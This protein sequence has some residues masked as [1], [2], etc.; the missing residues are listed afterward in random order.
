MDGD[1]AKHPQ[2]SPGAGRSQLVAEVGS[3]DLPSPVVAPPSARGLYLAPL[4][5]ERLDLNQPDG[6]HDRRRWQRP[7]PSPPEA[8][9]P[10]TTTAQ[11]AA[12][13]LDSGWTDAVL[14]P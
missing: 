9:Q 3:L 7:S 11:S 8:S 2:S 13:I 14:V 10:P 4:V 12:G 5:I 1:D 6:I